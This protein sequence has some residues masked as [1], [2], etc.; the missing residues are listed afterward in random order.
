M[1]WVKYFSVWKE[2]KQVIE[3]FAWQNLAFASFSIVKDTNKVSS[4]I[5]PKTKIRDISQ[6]PTFTKINI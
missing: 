6:N 2:K 4:C 1:K 5:F 3:V